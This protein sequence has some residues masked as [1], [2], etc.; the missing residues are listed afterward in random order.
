LAHDLDGL[1]QFVVFSVDGDRGN[2]GDRLA[3]FQQSDV[4]RCREK[5][6]DLRRVMGLQCLVDKRLRKF[7][8]PRIKHH[9]FNVPRDMIDGHLVDAAGLPCHRMGRR[10]YPP[11][12]DQYA[13][14]FHGYIGQC[15]QFGIRHSILRVIDII[16]NDDCTSGERK[17]Q[18]HQAKRFRQHACSQAGK[19]GGN[20]LVSIRA[21][22]VVRVDFSKSPQKSAL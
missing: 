15:R 8:V 19:D 4:V 7:L 16:T 2:I 9:T 22:N 18:Q 6:D 21:E 3:Q 14:A 1:S 17:N 11:W 12:I 20:S 13:M 10:D 5:R